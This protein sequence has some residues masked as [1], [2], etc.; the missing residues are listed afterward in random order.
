MVEVVMNTKNLDAMKPFTGTIFRVEH[1]QDNKGPYQDSRVFD[2][3][4]DD[5]NS[6]KYLCPQDDQMVNQDGERLYFDFCFHCGFDSATQLTKWFQLKHRLQLTKLGFKLAIYEGIKY[7][8]S[9]SDKQC[10]FSMG[11]VVPIHLDLP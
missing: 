2:W 7:F 3:D 11:N 6:D 5:H 4:S 8:K 9:E 1:P 10:Y